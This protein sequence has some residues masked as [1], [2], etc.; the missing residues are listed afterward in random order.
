MH[1]RKLITALMALQLVFLI[2][3]ILALVSQFQHRALLEIGLASTAI[4]LIIMGFSV[5]S[6]ANVVYEL[7]RL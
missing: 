3:F 4:N 1:K 5:L 6:I 2:I 7:H